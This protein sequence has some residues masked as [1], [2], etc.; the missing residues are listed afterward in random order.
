M[1]QP[2]RRARR[3]APIVEALRRAFD[4]TMKDPDFIEKM[5]AAKIEY[6]PTTGE[7]MAK[8]V[9]RTINT[10]KS[11]IDRYK[12]AIAGDSWE[13][14]FRASFGSGRNLQ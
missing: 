11:V 10:P 4:A 2:T 6:N 9:G 12:A 3:S 14:F 1:G 7:E 13:V 8:I 5:K